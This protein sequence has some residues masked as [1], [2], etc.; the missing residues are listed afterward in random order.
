M[1]ES[2]LII[3]HSALGDVIL[4]TAC[5]KAIRA[6]HPGA[7]IILLTTR[8][9]AQLLAQS[10]YFNEIWVDSRPRWTDREGIERYAVEIVAEEVLFL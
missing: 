1:T 2:I 9:Y 4:A 6:Q 7:E 10:P 8:P 5:F 3:K